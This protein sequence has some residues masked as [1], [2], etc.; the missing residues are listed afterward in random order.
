VNIELR[1]VEREVLVPSEQ[2]QYR[3]GRPV[4]VKRKERV[5]QYRE[6]IY[7]AGM[8]AIG[9]PGCWTD[10]WSDWTDVPVEVEK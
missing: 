4:M 10:K 2:V 1:W 7:E 9:I 6:R 5:L 8:P 3:D